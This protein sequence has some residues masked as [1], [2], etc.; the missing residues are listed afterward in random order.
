MS[1]QGKSTE[2]NANASAKD[3]LVKAEG[4]FMRYTCLCH[5]AAD[6]DALLLFPSTRVKTRGAPHEGHSGAH[7]R[8]H[9]GLMGYR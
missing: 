4:S 2:A 5:F 8:H 3:T 6:L 7:G 1:A 9:C